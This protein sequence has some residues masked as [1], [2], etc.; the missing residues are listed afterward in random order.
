MFSVSKRPKGG[1]MRKLVVL[2]SMLAAMMVSMAP[3]L[4][5]PVSVGNVKAGPISEFVTVAGF[6]PIEQGPTGNAPW[7]TDLAAAG[8]PVPPNPFALGANLP[9]EVNVAVGGVGPVRNDVVAES[10][11]F[12]GDFTQAGFGNLSADTD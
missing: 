11:F 3:A 6:S 5:D 4:A 1:S 12:G 7:G 8:N 10:H 2:V 9:F